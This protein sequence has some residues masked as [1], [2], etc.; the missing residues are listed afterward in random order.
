MPTNG[1]ADLRQV[2]SEWGY[3]PK[4]R[5][6]LGQVIRVYQSPNAKP[7]LGIAM[8]PD[9]E[10]GCEFRLNRWRWVWKAIDQRQTLEVPNMLPT[11][12]LAD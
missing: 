1:K 7:E 5:V 10:V 11:L 12:H 6:R 4:F 2:R 3:D 8:P 9:D